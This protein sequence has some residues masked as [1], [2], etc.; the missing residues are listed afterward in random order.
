MTCDADVKRFYG[1]L[2]ELE[3]R[4]GGT[5][6]VATCHGRMGWPSHGVYFFFEPGEERST[7]GTG[8]RVVR[9]GTHAVSKGS[10]T[11][12]WQRLSQ[13]RG[14]TSGNGQHRGSIFRLLVGEAL[15]RQGGVTLPSWGVGSSPGAAAVRVGST[16][17]GVVQAELPVEQHVS[18]VIGAMPFVWVAVD[19]EPGPQSVRSFIERNSIGLLSSAGLAEE[20]PPSAGW[21]G[22]SSTR[23]SV[24]RSG[25][26][27][28]NFVGAGYDPA[29]LDRFE[30]LV[31]VT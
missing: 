12:M 10:R 22:R 6:T 13:H 24:R 25:L 26:W 8:P 28:Q 3:T 11:S 4:V 21:L 23:D 7:S 16:R 2:G 15:I 20:D 29:F 5:R 17:P 14:T 9:V 1:L 19:D 30:E 18:Q 27:N 31:R